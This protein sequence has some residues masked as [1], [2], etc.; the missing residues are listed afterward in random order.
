MVDSSI[1][2][3]F[4]RVADN[5]LEKAIDEILNIKTL[6]GSRIDPNNQKLND[7]TSDVLSAICPCITDLKKM[8]CHDISILNEA[9]NALAESGFAYKPLDWEV[10]FNSSYDRLIDKQVKRYHQ[11][12]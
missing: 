4:L 12:S 9:G 10:L 11:K 8:Y 5:R 3:I 2:D 1:I 6:F 7:R